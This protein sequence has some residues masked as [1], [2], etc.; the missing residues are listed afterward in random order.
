MCC[1]TAYLT[2]LGIKYTHR[3]FLSEAL[4]CTRAMRAKGKRVRPPIAFETTSI[5]CGIDST[6]CWKLS[7]EIQVHVG[8]I[9]SD[10]SYRYFRC[11]FM[12]GISCSNISQSCSTRF[13]SGSDPLKNTEPM[14]PVW[15][16]HN[17]TLT[18]IACWHKAGGVHRFML[19]APNSDPTFCLPQQTSEFI[20]IH[21][22][23]LSSGYPSNCILCVSSN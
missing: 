10:N 12:L 1:L 3:T 23:G 9:E 6:R 19:L 15:D 20:M 22:R 8:M 21:P 2:T 16:D 17:T 13:R 5:P 11:I 7:F 4:Y 18:R 14:K